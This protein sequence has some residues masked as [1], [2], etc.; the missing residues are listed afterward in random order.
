MIERIMPMSLFGS[1]ADRDRKKREKAR[2][3]RAKQYERQQA[4]Y[5]RKEKIASS[6]H[7]KTSGLDKALSF[8]DNIL[9]IFSPS[10]GRF[11]HDQLMKQGMMLIVFV[12]CF[13]SGGFLCYQNYTKVEYQKAQAAN[14][15]TD[16]LEFSKSSTTVTPHTPFTTQD[17]KTVYIP[18][19][20][21]DMTNID[22]DASEYHIFVVG[23]NGNDIKSKITQAQLISYGSTGLM[24]LVVKS[25]NR[26]QS[27][28]VQFLMWSGSDITDD[29]YD[30]DD[31]NNSSLEEFGIIAKRYDTLGFAINLGGRSIKAIP[32]TKTITVKDTVTQKDPKTH[33]KVKVTK[34]VKQQIPITANK[35]LYNDNVPIFLYNHSV[36]GP[37]M[38][39]KRKTMAKKYARMQLAINRIEK[40]TRA[41]TKAGYILP[42]LPKWATNRGNDIAKSLPFSYDQLRSFDMLNPDTTFT[43]KQQKLL[44]QELRVYKKAQSANGDDVSDTTKEENYAASLGNKVIKNK[45][46]DKTLGNGNADGGNNNS[47]SDN[48]D[49]EWTELQ[50]EIA[51]IATLKHDLYY[52]MP[53]KIWDNYQ[54]FIL[55]TSSGSDK[56]ANT[57]AITFS[58][59]KGHNKHGNFMTIVLK[60]KN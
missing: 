23:K 39:K 22:P 3:K 2:A 5:E 7:Q 44:D 11:R 10:H 46:V 17:H 50:N 33:K 27:Q 49:A 38:A 41:L 34:M 53:L 51:Q 8:V 58:N 21:E 1:S 52:S 57:G 24:Y 13:V 6:I 26:F 29:H 20:I 16:D 4:K 30:P 47:D 31:N 42:K 37:Q 43:A 40:D 14:F 59:L 48:D 32:K 55:A 36:S 18:L 19:T 9:S 45:H 54:D 56:S 28:P 60:Q 35:D 12:I 15:M 25:L